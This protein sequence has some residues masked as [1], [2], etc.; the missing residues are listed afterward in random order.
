MTVGASKAVE[1]SSGT[2][3]SICY[4]TVP[5]E[6][7]TNSLASKLVETKLAAC[8]NIIPGIK[9]TY[10]WEGKV[11]QDSELLLMIKTRNSLREDLISFVKENHTYTVPEIICTDIAAGSPAYLKWVMDSTKPDL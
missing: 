1:N 10:F 2:G 9:S 8:V 11:N 4:V 5:D 6:A 7:S 3:L